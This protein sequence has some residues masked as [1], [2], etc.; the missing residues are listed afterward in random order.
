M[1][2]VKNG[3]EIKGRRK[4]QG[5]EGWKWKG[6]EN[7]MEVMKERGGDQ[8]RMDRKEGNES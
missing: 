3:G 4:W 7:Q 6:E 8:G 1:K 2:E 5:M